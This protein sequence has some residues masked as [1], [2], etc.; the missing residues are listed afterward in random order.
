MKEMMTA[1]KQAYMENPKDFICTAAIAV[2]GFGI[3]FVVLTY[4]AVLEGKM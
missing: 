2:V 1:L 4:G 3:L